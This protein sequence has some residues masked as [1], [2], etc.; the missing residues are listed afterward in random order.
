MLAESVNLL[1]HDYA[2]HPFTFDLAKELARKKYRVTYI[3][4]SANDTPKGDFSNTNPNLTVV[5]I[6]VFKVQKGNFTQRALHEYLYGKHFLKTVSDEK[7]DL[8]ISA[9]TPLQAQ[10]QILRWASTRQIP[11]IF[12]LQDL[13]S[14]AAKSILPQRLGFLGKIIANYFE[15]TEKQLLKS[16]D[17]I[18]AISDD[19]LSKL[20]EWNINRKQI[21]VIP[22]WAPIEKIP[23]LNRNNEFSQKIGTN[24]KF[25]IL[26]SGTLGMKHNPSLI[27]NTAKLLESE[28]DLLFVVITEGIGSRYLTTRLTTEPLQNLL[29]LPFQPFADLPMVLA[30]ADIILTILEEDAGAYCVPSKLWSSF[31]AGKPSVLVVPADNLASRVTIKNRT[32][33]VLEKHSP[34]LLADTLLKIRKDKTLLH[35]MGVNARRF[36]EHNFQIKNIAARF[37]TIFTEIL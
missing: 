12:W 15:Y 16:S 14:S 5:D 25:V 6:P 17:K 22:N 13:L 8:I 18:I 35:S 37:E 4:T 34:R 3:F 28:K 1:L 30:S 2:G 19:F 24:D 9:N 20:E 29:V 27:F 32:G 7:Y 31:C 36:A 11:F 23:L 10:K 26:Y 33:L 21:Q